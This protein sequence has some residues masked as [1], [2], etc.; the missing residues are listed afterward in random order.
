MQ[1]LTRRLRAGAL[2]LLVSGS[3]AGPVQRLD[4]QD[5][6][7]IPGTV[8]VP[9]DAAQT[10]REV[11]GRSTGYTGSARTF[12]VT[13]F[14][15][16]AQTCYAS[17]T[18]FRDPVDPAAWTFEQV[19]F[20]GSIALR[21]R[22]AGGYTGMLD[23]EPGYAA[24][25]A[26]SPGIRAQVLHASATQTETVTYDFPW[27]AGTS[28]VYGSLGVH[29]GG[30][31]DGWKAVDF[32]SDANTT[33]NHAPNKL[34]AAAPGTI[35]YVCDD[36]ANAAARIGDLI[37]VHLI[38]NPKLRVGQKIERGEELGQLKPGTYNTRCGY[39]SQQPQNFHVHL[40]FPDTGSFTM[41]GWTL[42]VPD[43]IWRRSTGGGT[44]TWRVGQWLRND[45]L[46]PPATPTPAPTASPCAFAGSGDANCDSQIDGV[47]YALWLNSRCERACGARPADFNGDGA[48]NDVD[49]SIWLDKRLST[50]AVVRSRTGIADDQRSVRLSV[51][52]LTAS[53]AGADLPLGV[54][55]DF[56]IR[57][58]FEP[59]ASGAQTETLLYARVAIAAP[60][61]VIRVTPGEL[62]VSASG[63]GRSIS[64]TRTVAEGGGVG[65]LITL[66]LGAK[67]PELA[68]QTQQ[69]V[70]LATFR[71][72]TTQRSLGA[73]FM[74][75]GAQFVSND[76][77][78]W[79]IAYAAAPF[80]IDP[81]RVY[82]PAVRKR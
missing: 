63:L 47:D 74:L 64:I 65:G 24:F 43:G 58:V 28:A 76:L 26:D 15:C 1:R 61:Q 73:W 48:V 21:R 30:Y 50:R 77:R 72:T 25:L 37:Y 38:G 18:G 22:S 12:A 53:S 27:Q 32:L 75:Y 55:V 42:T 51:V 56:A 8:T 79:P 78:A 31:I 39:A 35:T 6:V 2:C 82:L 71:V 46:P 62:D 19:T 10:V 59:A 44:Q 81:S 68:P 66:E 34:L 11:L 17:V 54:P 23:T 40:A 3:I 20:V 16:D 29:K 49:Y 52:P 5:P 67:T 4:A 45:A 33:L 57:A 9:G 14:D 41:G 80:A 70:T 69:T 13:S 7:V 60:G 36:G